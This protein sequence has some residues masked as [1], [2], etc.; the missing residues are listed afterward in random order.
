MLPTIK[1]LFMFVLLIAINVSLCKPLTKI[2]GSFRLSSHSSSSE[3]SLNKPDK[4][5]KIDKPTS[6]NKQTQ[7]LP[8]IYPILLTPNLMLQYLTSINS[9]TVDHQSN[10]NT[11][12][13]NLIKYIINDNLNQNNLDKKFNFNHSKNQLN[14]Q[15]GHLETNKILKPIIN[16]KLMFNQSQFNLRNDLR[17]DYEFDYDSLMYKLGSSREH[18]FLSEFFKLDNPVENAN[19]ISNSHTEQASSFRNEFPI[20]N[21]TRYPIYYAPTDNNQY[22]SSTPKVYSTYLFPVYL[23]E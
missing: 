12:M 3:N 23:P 4:N 16:D 10:A 8:I 11:P 18:D 15:S 7:I 21:E 5:D 22:L 20:M 9:P 6:S 17:N 1:W 2:I 13:N 19:R 14:R